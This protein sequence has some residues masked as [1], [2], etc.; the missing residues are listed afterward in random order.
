[1]EVVLRTR[2]GLELEYSHL[3]LYSELEVEGV[4]E[5]AL[6][7]AFH[8]TEKSVYSLKV[9]GEVAHLTVVSLETWP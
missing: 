8:L 1:L 6:E 4:Q 9:K 3:N 2:M 5:P 7:Y